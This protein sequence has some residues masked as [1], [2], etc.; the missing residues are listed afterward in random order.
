MVKTLG[1]SMAA[2]LAAAIVV[3]S[4]GAAPTVRAQAR[5]RLTFA[6]RT[7]ADLRDWDRQLDSM[8][9]GGE[10]RVRQRLPD[11]L[12]PGRSHERMAQ[13]YKGV[14][15]FGG[16]VVRQFASNGQVVSA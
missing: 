1:S 4:L 2:S 13:Y 12:V 11:L 16:D 8:A 10:L 15:V 5:G 6:A 3:F 7:T 9:R 14:R